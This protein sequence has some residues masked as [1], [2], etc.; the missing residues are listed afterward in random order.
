MSDPI[1]A[2]INNI[3]RESNNLTSNANQQLQ[4]GVD[5][6]S[7]TVNNI[8]T[9][10]NQLEQQVTDQLDGLVSKLPTDKDT[11]L[12]KRKIEAEK[13]EIKAR[14]D[15]IKLNLKDV[16]LDELKE[17]VASIE[18]PSIP[19]PPKIPVIDP[20]L[21]QAYAIAKQFK[22]LYKERQKLSRKNLERGKEIFSYPMKEI[23]ARLRDGLPEQVTN[24]PQLP[25]IP[26]LPL[27]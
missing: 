22:D 21:L 2:A 20:K 27:K 12:I 18:L 1:E 8:Q 17:K 3:S 23:P 19:F 16:V 5:S 9:E 6:V 11:E 26:D 24:L 13:L 15:A 25:D 10:I 4:A 7:N 14:L